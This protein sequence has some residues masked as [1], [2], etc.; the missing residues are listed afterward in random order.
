MD[1]LRLVKLF[2]AKIIIYHLLLL[3][4]IIIIPPHHLHLLTMQ[5]LIINHH[6]CFIIPLPP[7]LLL[8]ELLHIILSFTHFIQL[9]PP[10]IHYPHPHLNLLI[11]L[12]QYHYFALIIII[13]FPIIHPHPPPNQSI[14]FEEYPHFLHSPIIIPLP[15]K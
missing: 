14:M 11:K 12:P 4:L 13:Y 10:S 6:F 1:L 5:A 9:L 3:L 2:S 15:L 7:I 8:I